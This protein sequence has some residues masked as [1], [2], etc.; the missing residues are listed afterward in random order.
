MSE[1]VYER[2]E[3]TTSR[4]ELLRRLERSDGDWLGMDAEARFVLGYPKRSG[5]ITGTIGLEVHRAGLP[6][7]VHSVRV[8]AAEATVTEPFET[9]AGAKA[10]FASRVEEARETDRL[11]IVHVERLVGGKVVE[12]ESVSQNVSATVEELL[13]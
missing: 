2:L 6:D 12:H 5:G 7:P 3:S 11:G 10:H 9:E 13:D 4:T 8:I 1:P